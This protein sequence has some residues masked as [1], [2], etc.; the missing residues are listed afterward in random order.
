MAL[1]LAALNDPLSGARGDGGVE[2][3]RRTT[4]A[5]ESLL[6]SAYETALLF[7][8][9]GKRE[10]AVR[11]L[12]GILRNALMT[13]RD[14]D[15]DDAPSLTP[16]MTQVKFLALKNLGR[17]V[18]DLAIER[19]DAGSSGSDDDDDDDDDDD[20]DADLTAT[21]RDLAAD[22][23]EALRAYAA[24]VEIDATDS[25]LWRRL[26]ALASR[27]NLLHLARHALERGL[28]AR[29]NHPLLL[30]DLAE[31]LLAVGDY[32]ACAHVAGLLLRL[33]PRHSR[34]R[35]MRAGG[36]ARRDCG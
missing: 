16:T 25:S 30:E 34:A 12:R 27:R 8:R 31:V 23:A 1:Q 20:A 5:E 13:D 22:Y 15:D 3:A 19:E 24:A 28:V 18:A 10:D 7:I 4:E 11:E 33:D 21:E 29:P 6:T 2:E 32:P 14:D 17:L 35:E 26:G 9:D 36:R